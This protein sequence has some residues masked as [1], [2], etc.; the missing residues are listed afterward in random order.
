MVELR[1]RRSLYFLVELERVEA[2]VPL[3]AVGQAAGL[4]NADLVKPRW[5]DYRKRFQHDCVNKREDRSARADAQSQRQH[6]CGGKH[7]GKPELSHCMANIGQNGHWMNLPGAKLRWTLYT[8]G[9]FRGTKREGM[10]RRNI[11]V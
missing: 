4:A 5:I 10:P 3:Q 2:P 7:R 11:D 9:A 8:L 1:L 6:Q